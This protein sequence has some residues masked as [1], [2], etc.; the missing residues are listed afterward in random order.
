MLLFKQCKA[1]WT[2]L[3]TSKSVNS[4]SSVYCG[5]TSM[6][7]GIFEEGIWTEFLSCG[8]ISFIALI[9][10]WVW[11]I[12]SLR[13]K[14]KFMT[15]LEFESCKY[16]A[17]SMLACKLSACVATT[18]S[19]SI[20]FRCNHLW[21]VL[22]F[23]FRRCLKPWPRQLPLERPLNCL[24]QKMLASFKK[25]LERDRITFPSGTFTN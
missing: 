12:W 24:C 14:P 19:E 3:L 20:P 10:G 11:Q 1:V 21:I 23:Y 18:C 15:R 8:S 4:V 9:F 22:T 7:D 16:K 2:V 17:P 6:S 25:I 5:G 13:T